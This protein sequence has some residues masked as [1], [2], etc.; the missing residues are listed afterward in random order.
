MGL[1]SKPSSALS[2]LGEANSLHNKND[3]GFVTKETEQ[4]KSGARRE[5]ETRPVLHNLITPSQ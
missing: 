5:D 2:V 3:R 4:Q 1:I